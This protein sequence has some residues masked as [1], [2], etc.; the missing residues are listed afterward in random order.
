MRVL[1]VKTSSLGDLIHTFPALT[2][3]R[4]EFPDIEF[5]WVV[6]E[7]FAEVPRWH[8]A[9]RNVIPIAIRRWRRSWWNAWRKGEIRAFKQRLRTHEYDH[10]IDAQGLLKSALPARWARGPLVGYDPGS[11]KETLASRFYRTKVAVSRQLHAVE[12]VRQLFAAALNY[13]VP[14]AVPDYGLGL[15]DTEA[16]AGDELVLLHGTT[17]PSKHWPEEYWAEL[18]DLGRQAGMHVM[19]PWGD[20]EDRLRAERIIKMAGSGHL[21]PKLSLTALARR[22][23]GARAIVGVD[24][25]LVHLAAAVGVP[26]IGIYGPTRVDLTGAVG[27]S[28]KNLPAD[29]PCAPCM[30][31]ECTYSGESRVKPACFERIKPEDVWRELGVLV[32]ARQ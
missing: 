15:E 28:Q 3:A 20:A 19:L 17:W 31:R 13:P 11:I 8:P 14:D 9:V 24:S 2:D 32:R 30:Q 27:T 4:R 16:T 25:G 12:R 22:L 6:E 18:A 26:S 5:D 7:G 21:L 23:A 10:V 29:F 1:I